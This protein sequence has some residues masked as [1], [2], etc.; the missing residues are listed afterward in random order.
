MAEMQG[1]IE[2]NI[3]KISDRNIGTLFFFDK[4]KYNVEIIDK[5][6]KKYRNR[7]KF[8]PSQQMPYITLSGVD[9]N[10]KLEQIKSFLEDL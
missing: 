4:E 10:E 6:M 5:L 9:E 3:Y 2:K 8:S 7:I 1:V